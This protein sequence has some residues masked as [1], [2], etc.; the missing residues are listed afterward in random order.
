MEDDL[1]GDDAKKAQSKKLEIDEEEE[2]KNEIRNQL[3]G[4]ALIE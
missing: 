1:G 3:T 4:Q 2:K